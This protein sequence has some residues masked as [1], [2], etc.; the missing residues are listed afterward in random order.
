MSCIW[1]DIFTGADGDPPDP[2]KWSKVNS[3]DIQSNA[4]ELTWNGG[5]Q[6]SISPI[7][8][9]SGDFDIQ[10][11]FALQTPPATNSWIC[12]MLFYIDASHQV[13]IAVLYDGG[14]KQFQSGYI[15]G[16]GWNYSNAGRTNNTGKLRLLRSGTN[17]TPYFADGAGAFTALG[18]VSNLSSETGTITIANGAWGGSPTIT[19]RYDNFTFVTGCPVAAISDSLTLLQGVVIANADSLAMLGSNILNV[20]S[21]I[22][23]SSQMDFLSALALSAGSGLVSDD[24]QNV[25]LNALAKISNKMSSSMSNAILFSTVAKISFFEKFWTRKPITVPSFPSA[26]PGVNWDTLNG[27]GPWPF[28]P[29]P[30]K[31]HYNEG[32]IISNAGEDVWDT[33]ITG[34]SITPQHRPWC[35]YWFRR[36]G[37]GPPPTAPPF[38]TFIPWTHPPPPEPTIAPPTA[39]PTTPTPTSPPWTFPPGTT[40]PPCVGTII[41]T[42]ST[43]GFNEEQQ[44][45]VGG[46]SPGHTFTWE[47]DDGGYIDEN[48]GLYTSPDSN[49]NCIYKPIIKLY[50]DGDLIDTFNHLT[51]TNFSIV[52]LAYQTGTGCGS[53]LCMP[54]ANC[55]GKWCMC[56]S[57][58]CLLEN[59]EVTINTF[60][61]SDFLL[62]SKLKSGQCSWCR[63]LSGTCVTLATTSDN[64]GVPHTFETWC[65]GPIDIRSAADL[66]AGCCPH[67]FF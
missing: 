46:G 62:N 30:N 39:G 55:P 11:D 51:I 6:D 43:M 65:A 21:V 18:A 44:F 1:D 50:C 25:T 41:Y 66:L 60:T 53:T 35:G 12:Q 13:Y 28:S 34:R 22:A 57:P 40:E 17:I 26:G 64:N 56:E 45:T 36:T 29:Q 5:V 24:H 32:D 42:A 52:I 47:V 67:E 14:S 8:S 61:C 20:G 7:R 15:H 9:I 2:V 58:I 38:A 48:T 27:L 10:V 37:T 19:C 59:C 33:I 4:V 31:P 54:D 49:P 23:P 16:G 63:G 3:P